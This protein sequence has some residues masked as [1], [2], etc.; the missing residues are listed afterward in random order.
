MTPFH[1]FTVK[2]H[3]SVELLF[4][5]R[6]EKD[7][8]WKQQLDELTESAGQRLETYLSSELSPQ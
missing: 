6:Q 2:F 5:N 8:L 1:H 7:I 4:A 3:R